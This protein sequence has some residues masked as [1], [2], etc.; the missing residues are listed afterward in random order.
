MSVSRRQFVAG[1]STAIAAMAGGRLGNLVFAADGGPQQNTTTHLPLMVT[2]DQIFVMVFLRGGCDA[3]SLVTPYDDGVYVNKRGGDP[4]KW[5]SLVVKDPLTIDPRNAAFGATSSFGLH[6]KAA[7]FKELYDAGKLAI[8]HACG[9]DDSTRSHFDAMDFIERG[10]PGDKTTG[11]GWL[12]RHL[13][14]I[15]ESASLLPTISAGSNAP[16]SLLGYNE[17]VVMSDINNYGLSGPYRYNSSTNPAMLNV[18][19]DLYQGSGAFV[20]AGKRALEVINAIQDLKNQNGGKNLSYTPDAGVLYPNGGLAGSLKLL[21]QVIKLNMGLRI[22]TVDFGGWDTHD[23][24]GTNGGYYSNQVATLT[25]ALHAFYNDLPAYRDRLNIVVMSEFGRRLGRNGGIG[26]DHGHGGAMF[27]LGGKV[28]GGKMYGSW[29]GLQNL[30][31]NQDLRTTTDYRAVLGELL[32]SR[33]GNN[34]L[35]TVF[36][37]LKA[38][39]AGKLGYKRLGIVSDSELAVELAV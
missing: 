37:G 29:P 20:D 1:C 39:A 14:V 31:Q 25:S 3:L 32:A 34:K 24:Q 26:T 28:N 22:A 5:D 23:N 38:D 27:V 21:A 8:V 12:S 6:P 17:S 18:I 36:P 10:T 4:S 7:P 35:S 11:Q 15:G 19:N 30:D 2:P 13:S 16:A 9:L 33:M